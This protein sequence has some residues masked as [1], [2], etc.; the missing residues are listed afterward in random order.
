MIKTHWIAFCSLALCVLV[1]PAVSRGQAGHRQVDT[2]KTAAGEL[3]ITASTNTLIDLLDSS[4]VD[5]ITVV[6]W[7]LSQIGG[8]GVREKLLAL[9][10]STN[11]EDL[12]EY[13]DSALDNLAFTEEFPDI[14]LLEFPDEHDDERPRQNNEE[15][16]H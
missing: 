14:D 7:S 11:D 4:D 1:R 5:L 8:E 9:F 12:R 13:M 3:R 2:I 6:I 10:D 15:T 16:T